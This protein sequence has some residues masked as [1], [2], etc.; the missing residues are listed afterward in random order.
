MT[1]DPKEVVRRAR[2]DLR[3]C[4]DPETTNP[5]NISHSVENLARAVALEE[6]DAFAKKLTETFR[7]VF[8]LAPEKK[9]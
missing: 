3:D 9:S 6:I 8:A 4:F 2:L 7:E 1:I 5:H